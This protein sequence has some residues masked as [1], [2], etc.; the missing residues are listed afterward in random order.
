MAESK[1]QFES[2]LHMEHVAFDKLIFQ[3]QGFGTK[4]NKTKTEFQFEVGIAKGELVK[5]DQEDPNEH[6]RVTLTAKAD[7]KTEFTA[8]V[9]LSG[10]FAID[11]HTEHKDVLL[12]QNA[13]AV[14]F[15]YLRSE[16]TLL[17]SQPET[18]PVVLPVMNIAEMMDSAEKENIPAQEQNQLNG[19]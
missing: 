17:T 13:V 7:R 4:N 18:H 1:Q 8:T 10:Y 15:P 19:K 14:L 16:F 2:I 6:Y 12:K 3:R 11:K 5:Q 9:C